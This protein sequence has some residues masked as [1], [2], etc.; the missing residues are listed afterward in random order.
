MAIQR[1]RVPMELDF[2]GRKRQ[3]DEPRHR[4]FADLIVSRDKEDFD[5]SAAASLFSS[6]SKFHVLGERLFI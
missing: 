6:A 2:Q 5:C 3:Q 4:Q 1:R